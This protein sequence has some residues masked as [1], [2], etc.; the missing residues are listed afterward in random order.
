MLSEWSQLT[1]VVTRGSFSRRFM[2]LDSVDSRHK[3][4]GVEEPSPSLSLYLSIAWRTQARMWAVYRI[5]S[6]L[7]QAWCPRV[8]R[9]F[10]NNLSCLWWEMTSSRA[11][12]ASGCS[13]RQSL[14][15]RVALSLR[16]TCNSQTNSCMRPS[17]VVILLSRVFV[18]P[19]R[20]FRCRFCFRI[21]KN[22]LENENVWLIM[23]TIMMTPDENKREGKKSKL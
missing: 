11:V 9:A 4:D 5:R 10:L 14:V 3:M 7:N 22:N 1:L 8:L 6:G 19:S 16:V 20:C 23:M 2:E 21:A 15:D 18:S 17:S 13:F 12:W